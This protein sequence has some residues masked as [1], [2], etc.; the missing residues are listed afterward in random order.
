MASKRKGNVKKMGDLNIYYFTPYSTSKNIAEEYNKY[1]ELV[2]ND[3][4]WICLLDADI[5]F[6]TPD[7]GSQIYDTISSH[8]DVGIFT[9]YTNRV[10][11][12]WQCHEGVIN[13]NDSIRNHHTISRFLRKKHAYQLTNIKF[14]ISGYFM[15]FSK[16]TWK[17]A[18]KFNE[19]L[20]MLGVDTDFSLNVLK[21][22]KKIA[23]MQGLYVFH[24]YRLVE[25]IDSTN[26]LK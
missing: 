12:P 1:I 19:S 24:Y 6:L 3:D 10:G 26:H 17:E 15:A 2:P 9:C 20:G 13:K 8:K 21:L 18:G 11:S 14:P 7:Y 23:L 5:M 22:G 4:D 25:G 16:K